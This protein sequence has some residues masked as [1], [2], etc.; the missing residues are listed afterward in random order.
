MTVKM[1]GVTKI[2][3]IGKNGE[4][5]VKSTKLRKMDRWILSNWVRFQPSPL[6]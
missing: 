1:H 4:H 5:I 6:C 2:K 3:R